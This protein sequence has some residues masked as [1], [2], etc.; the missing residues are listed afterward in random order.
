MKNLVAMR[1]QIASIHGEQAQTNTKRA[2]V[3]EHLRSLTNSRGED[4][5]NDI[6]RVHYSF[7]VGAA[8]ASEKLDTGLLLVG[9]WRAQIGE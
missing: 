5:G 8:T 7:G 6:T 1:T 3:V 9:G 4:I 2:K